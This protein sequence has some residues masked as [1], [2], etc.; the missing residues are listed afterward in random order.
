MGK[1]NFRDYEINFSKLSNGIHEFNFEVDSDFFK[2]FELSLIEE[3]EGE[4]FLE[5]EKSE[6]MLQLRFAIKASI[7]LICD[8][9]LKPFDYQVNLKQN[10]IVKFGEEPMELSED[11]IVIDNHAVS[12]NVAEYIYQFISLE[13][14]YKK[15][16]PDLVG[17]ERPDMFYE[18]HAN[19][20]NK[21]KSIDPRW[22]A[23]KN[24][25]K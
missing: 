14:P 1:R 25:K 20:D 23:L 7:K 15:I 18:D 2:D 16:H 6:T 4:V 17:E 13:I 8:I 19:E 11:V 12:L 24:L 9:S 22:E 21:K 10:L 5:F 3:G